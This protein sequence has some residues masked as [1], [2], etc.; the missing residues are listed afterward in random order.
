METGELKELLSG[1]RNRFP[2]VEYEYSEAQGFGT[3]HKESSDSSSQQTTNCIVD[4][5]CHPIVIAKAVEQVLE[6]S[7]RK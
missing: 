1:N 3:L 7:R 2:S 6:S 4:A 5:L